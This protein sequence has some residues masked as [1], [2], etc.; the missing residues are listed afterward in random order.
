MQVTF[1]TDVAQVTTPNATI[2][3]TQRFNLTGLTLKGNILTHLLPT[4][5]NF[6]NDIGNEK[7]SFLLHHN[8]SAKRPLPNNNTTTSWSCN[9]LSEKAA[10]CCGETKVAAC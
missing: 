5:H 10:R 3:V 7:T 1:A 6:R 8:V 4:D 9:H 2:K